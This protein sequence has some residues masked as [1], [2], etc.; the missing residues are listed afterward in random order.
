MIWNTKQREVSY[1]VKTD[2]LGMQNVTV[3]TDIYRSYH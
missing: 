1:M 2:A 3:Y